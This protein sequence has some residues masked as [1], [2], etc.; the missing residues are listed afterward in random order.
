MYIVAY[1]CTYQILNIVPYIV[2]GKLEVVERILR[3]AELGPENLQ[4]ALR[5][6]IRATIEVKIFNIAYSS[7]S[8]LTKVALLCTSITGIFTGTQYFALDPKFSLAMLFFGYYSCVIF[9][10]LYGRAYVI[11]LKF[12]ELKR[13]LTLATE[14]CRRSGRDSQGTLYAQKLTRA[15]PPCGV[16]AGS[17]Y[18]LDRMSTPSFLNFVCYQVCC[19]FLTVEK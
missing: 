14:Q 13:K 18:I 7:T 4:M 10:S 17:F 6:M 15:I 2:D 9:A 19:L 12:D 3:Q 8:Y 11:P 16:R 5:F 1:I